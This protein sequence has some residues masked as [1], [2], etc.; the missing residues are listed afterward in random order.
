MWNKIKR[1][2]PQGSVLG[3]LLYNVF[4]NDIFMFI[5]KSGTCNFA[6]DNTIYDCG[7]NLSSILES[8]KQDMKIL[9]AWFTINSSLACPDKFHFMNL[10]SKN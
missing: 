1:G 2:A 6:D 10:G 3:P 4:V 9:L 5:E 7:N 8:L